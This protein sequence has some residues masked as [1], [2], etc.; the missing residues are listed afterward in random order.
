MRQLSPSKILGIFV[1]LF[2]LSRTGKIIE[3][4]R[5]LKPG[6]FL[7]LAPLKASR[8]PEPDR[9]VVTLALLALIWLTVYLLLQK[10]K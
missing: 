3:F 5:Q 8:C 4:F 9:F 1:L 10:W 2:L 7:T 6:E